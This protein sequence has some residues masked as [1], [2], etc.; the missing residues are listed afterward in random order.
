MEIITSKFALD[1]NYDILYKDAFESCQE[2]YICAEQVPSRTESINLMSYEFFNR[3]DLNRTEKNR[4][5]NEFTEKALF[6]EYV[7]LYREIFNYYDQKIYNNS[8]VLEEKEDDISS[9]QTAINSYATSL[10][11]NAAAA[12]QFTIYKSNKVLLTEA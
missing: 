7:E 10:S 3:D 9:L 12:S 8:L 5:A 1:L 6:G 11:G 4:Q 2:D